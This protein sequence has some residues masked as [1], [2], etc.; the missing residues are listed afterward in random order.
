MDS[1]GTDAGAPAGIFRRYGK[2]AGRLLVVSVFS[3]VLGQSL[4]VLGYSWLGWPFAVS[5]AAAVAVSAAPSYVLT[6]YWVW[7]KR[8]KNLLLS[9]VLPYWGFAFLGLFLSTVAAGIADIYSDA[10]VVLN[11]VNLAVYA[12]LW[13]FRFLVF[14]HLMFGRRP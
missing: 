12:L 14:E 13:M 7:E 11:I 4:L 6:R 9:E 10:Q 5:N 8:S 3:T 1:Q 2:K